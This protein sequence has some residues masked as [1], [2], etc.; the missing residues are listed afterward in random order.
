MLCGTEPFPE[1]FRA[2]KYR[3][4]RHFLE[5]EDFRHI[6]RSLPVPVADKDIEEMFSYADK[7]NDGKLSYQEFLVSGKLPTAESWNFNPLVPGVQ[8][9]ISQLALSDFCRLNLW[10]KWQILTLTIVSCD[11]IG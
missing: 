7:D 5:K 11:V 10:R 8:K 1:D 3:L 4:D 2:K 9:K 6:M